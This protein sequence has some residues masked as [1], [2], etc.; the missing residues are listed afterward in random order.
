MG[1]DSL[2]ANYNVK[3]VRVLVCYA[4]GPSR[5]HVLYDCGPIGM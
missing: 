3:L 2:W 5:M 1:P 4:V